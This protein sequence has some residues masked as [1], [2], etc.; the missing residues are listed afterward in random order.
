MRRREEITLVSWQTRN[1]AS[2]IAAGY[3]T[4]GKGNPALDSATVLA[5]DEIEAEQIKEAQIKFASSGGSN[6]GS[7][8]FDDAGEIIYAGPEPTQGTFE[9]FMGSMGNPHRWAGR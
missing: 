6:S 2:F 4:D 5:F 1:L 3:M 7:P 8:Q 9:R